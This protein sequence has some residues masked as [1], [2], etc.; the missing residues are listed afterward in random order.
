MHMYTLHT[1]VTHIWTPQ[2]NTV[3]T[4]THI[5]RD[6]TYTLHTQHKHSH[7]CTHAHVHTHM[8]TRTCTHAHVHTHMYTHM[9]TSTCTHKTC[10][11]TCSH[12]QTHMY[13][14]TCTHAHAYTHTP[15]TN[16]NQQPVRH[17]K[18]S[19]QLTWV[20]TEYHLW[21]VVVT[22]CQ[23]LPK[24]LVPH[25]PRHSRLSCGSPTHLV[26][27]LSYSDTAQLQWHS[28]ISVIAQLQ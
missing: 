21:Q 14:R 15:T 19:S 4:H 20:F 3:N 11:Y 8:Y 23:Q 27:Q 25:P 26:T 17:E 10:T 28:S 6:I 16:L 13:I 18:L 2:T 9:F 5:N 22:L 1:N 7:T 12:T 24:P